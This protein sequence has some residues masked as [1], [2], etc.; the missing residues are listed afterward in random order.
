MKMNNLLYHHIPMRRPRQ[1]RLKPDPVLDQTFNEEEIRNKFRFTRNGVYFI[2]DLLHDDLVRE[3]DR[4]NALSVMTQV[5]TGLRFFADHSNQNNVGELVGVV[6]SSVSKVCRD[7]SRALLN[8][9]GEFIYFPNTQ[10]EKNEIKQEFYDF[11]GMPSVLGCIDG[12]HVRIVRPKDNEADFV[13]RKNFHSINVQVLTDSKYR[14]RDVVARWPGPTH[15][16]FIFTSS[17]IKTYLDTHNTRLQDGII[18]GDSGYALLPYLMTP[19]LNPATA[20]ERNYNRSHKSTR[21]SVE[22]SIGQLKRRFPLLLYTM[23]AD[24]ETACLHIAAACVLHNIAKMLNEPDFEG[25][26]DDDE[27]DIDPRLIQ[28]AHPN[29]P[30]V[31]RYITTTFF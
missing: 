16:S 20:Q 18:L 4:N 26:D 22:K 24:P 3:T 1:Y 2:H 23:R 29:G 11:A 6:K 31:R 30:I 14:I 19:Y 10:A 15:D 28:P 21:S 5:Q 13:N 12:T 25:D 27:M 9:A 17:Y 7:F 8:H